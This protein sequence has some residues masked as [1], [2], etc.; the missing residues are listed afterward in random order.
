M[1]AVEPNIITA[2]YNDSTNPRIYEKCTR[3]IMDRKR[4]KKMNITEQKKE[5][6]LYWAY[7][8]VVGLY[9]F[10]RFGLDIMLTPLFIFWHQTKL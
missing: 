4:M 9:L 8:C 3:V 5:A 1:S 7:V 6:Q 2:L 10:L